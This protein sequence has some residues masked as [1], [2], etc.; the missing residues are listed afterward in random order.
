VT[1]V[2]SAAIPP[3]FHMSTV[4]AAG[5]SLDTD[6]PKI[7]I[8]KTGEMQLRVLLCNNSCHGFSIFVFG[9][10]N[11]SMNLLRTY[12]FTGKWFEV[13]FCKLKFRSQFSLSSV[14]KLGLLW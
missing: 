11:T 12:R 2:S 7:W 4:L 14:F 1:T 13:R 10:V 5:Q 8:P 9:A 6:G 3:C